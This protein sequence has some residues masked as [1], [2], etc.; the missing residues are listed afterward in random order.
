MKTHIVL[1]HPEA[2][3]FNAHL[4]GISQSALSAAGG[5]CTLSD[6]YAMDFD[7]REGAHHYTA[8]KDET[9]FHVQ[10]EQ[11][12]NAEN[13][14]T[15]ADVEAEAKCLLECDLLIVHFPLWW[16]GPPAILKGWMDR[17]FVYGRLYRSTM[18]YDAGIC[19]GKKMLACV[20]TGASEDN[21]APN[22][23]EGDTRLHLWPILYPFRYL[24]FDVLQPEVMHGVGSTAFLE[25]HEGGLSTLDA[26][27]S[28]WAAALEALS[29]RP[30]V[31]YNRDTDFDETKRLLPGA[32]TY[33][34]FIQHTP[35]D[36]T[37]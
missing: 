7:P 32:P 8:R 35:T 12:F 5:Q 10:T 6:L 3:S 27:S 13:N 14:T 23:R 28:R 4:A 29:S 34:P 33:S 36:H 22:G 11:R 9:A 24:G 26:Y 31:Q 16:F 2:S 19:A 18:R 17:V 30:Q 21:C 1:A 15:P 37:T 25:G 20:T